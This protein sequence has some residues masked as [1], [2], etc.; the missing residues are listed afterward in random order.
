MHLEEK[1]FHLQLPSNTR[2]ET[3]MSRI[4]KGKV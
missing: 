3:L 1:G 2:I 4:A